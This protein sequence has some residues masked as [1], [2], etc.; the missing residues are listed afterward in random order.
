MVGGQKQTGNDIIIISPYV[1]LLERSNYI[2]FNRLLSSRTEYPP[3]S[4]VTLTSFYGILPLHSSFRYILLYH[5]SNAG[6]SPLH[7][8]L[9]SIRYRQ[10]SITSFSIILSLRTFSHFILHVASFLNLAARK[11]NFYIYKTPYFSQKI[12][13]DDLLLL[14]H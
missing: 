7:P 11:K 10:L 9:S 2:R 4:S 3:P 13:N 12:Y 8:F 1:K 14:R 5:P 6:S